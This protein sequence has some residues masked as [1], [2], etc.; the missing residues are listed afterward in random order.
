METMI[1]NGVEKPIVDSKEEIVKYAKG[2]YKVAKYSN[3]LKVCVTAAILNSMGEERFN[4]IINLFQITKDDYIGMICY[5]VM[6]LIKK[7]EDEQKEKENQWR[8]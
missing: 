4:Q 1:I 2:L 7:E 8:K 6:E 5:E 3:N